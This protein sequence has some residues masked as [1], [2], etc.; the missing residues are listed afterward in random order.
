MRLALGI[1]CSMM[2]LLMSNFTVHPRTRLYIIPIAPSPSYSILL[3]TF[4]SLVCLRIVDIQVHTLF[5][6]PS[7]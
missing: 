1:L 2:L 7:L 3:D 4:S 6:S 5:T